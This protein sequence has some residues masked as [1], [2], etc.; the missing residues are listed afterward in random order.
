V[1]ALLRSQQAQVRFVDERR[2]LKRV[3]GLFVGQFLGS[4]KAKFIVDKRQELLGGGRIALLD[5]RQDAGDVAHEDK[6]SRRKK[7][8]LALSRAREAPPPYSD[9]A[10]YSLHWLAQMNRRPL[11]AR[12]SSSLL[13]QPSATPSARWLLATFHSEMINLP[14]ESGFALLVRSSDFAFVLGHP[15]PPS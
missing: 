13:R 14:K 8:R 11:K 15:S 7:D 12:L 1:L 5:G 9:R 2:R 3:A 6:H 4:E 10:S